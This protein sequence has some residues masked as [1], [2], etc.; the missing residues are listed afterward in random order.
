MFVLRQFFKDGIVS[1]MTI[2]ENYQVIT[3]QNHKE[4]FDKLIGGVNSHPDQEK[5]YA[6]LV[7]NDG[8]KTYPLYIGFIYYIMTDGGKTFENLT[9]K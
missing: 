2:G 1:N 8:S 7:Y 4:D 9:F 5:I 3:K 6:I